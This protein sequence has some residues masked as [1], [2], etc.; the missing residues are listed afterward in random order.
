MNR[1]ISIPERETT[2]DESEYNESNEAL[3]LNARRD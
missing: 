3:T 1:K 2:R